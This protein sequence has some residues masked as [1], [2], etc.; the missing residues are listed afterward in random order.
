LE[1][2]KCSCHLLAGRFTDK[3]DPVLTN[4]TQSLPQPLIITDPLTKADQALTFLSPYTWHK[5]TLGHYK[6]SAGNQVE[7]FLKLHK[8]SDKKIKFMLKCY[9]TPVEVRT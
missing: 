7:Q 8:K 4:V 6:E 5:K 9:L 3:G 1:L 2:S